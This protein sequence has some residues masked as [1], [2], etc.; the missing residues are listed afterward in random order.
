MSQSEKISDRHAEKIHNLVECVRNGPGHSEPRLR[1]EVED[2]VA[3]HTNGLAIDETRLPQEISNYVD[4]IALHAYKVT[5]DDIT[6]LI[7]AGHTEDAIF[8]LTLSAALGAGMTRLKSGMAALR[9]D[10]DAA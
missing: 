4:K 10:N 5:D 3:A 6:A 7:D 2:R 8:E 9:G 1:R